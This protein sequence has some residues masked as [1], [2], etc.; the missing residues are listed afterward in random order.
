V[1][2]FSDVPAPYWYYEEQGSADEPASVETTITASAA[3]ELAIRA[4]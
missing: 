4:V 2:F 3:G 1:K